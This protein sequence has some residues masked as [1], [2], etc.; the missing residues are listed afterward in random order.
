MDK[1]NDSIQI[2]S[3]ECTHQKEMQLYNKSVLVETR[4]LYT[5]RS[6]SMRLQIEK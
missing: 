3:Q 5:Y 6:S 1:E 4:Q 2:A